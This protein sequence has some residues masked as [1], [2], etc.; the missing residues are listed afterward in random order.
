MATAFLLNVMS[1]PVPALFSRTAGVLID[2]RLVASAVAPPIPIRRTDK[3]AA[4]AAI[5]VTNAE[6]VTVG[7]FMTNVPR[8]PAA[9]EPMLIPVVD[10]E[11]PPV[12][13]LT[14]FVRPVVVAPLPTLAVEVPAAVPRDAVAAET[15]NV[16]LNTV[17]PVKV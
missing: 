15:V 1:M 11:S 12:P 17:V 7:E 14:V 4:A 16:P 2:S 5:A 8:E 13:R 10:P 6:K 9:A 3:F